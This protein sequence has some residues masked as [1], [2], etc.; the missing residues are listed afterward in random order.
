MHLQVTSW[1][2]HHRVSLHKVRG[3][4]YYTL[5][6]YGLPLLYIGSIIFVQCMAELKYKILCNLIISWFLHVNW[7]NILKI[8]LKNF[9]NE[10]F[11]LPPYFLLYSILTSSFLIL[12]ST[13]TL[14]F[15]NSL[16]L[17]VCLM[18]KCPRNLSHGNHDSGYHG[19]DFK[20]K[21]KA[22]R[23]PEVNLLS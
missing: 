21:I 5:K 16:T 15:N 13:I 1:C 11:F 7:I 10:H 20:K 18:S 6:L 3:A 9:V 4:A 19:N 2:E 23:I 22:W 17:F 14:F 8:I 12:P